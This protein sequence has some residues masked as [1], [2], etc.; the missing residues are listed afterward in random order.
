MTIT[1]N[2]YGATTEEWDAFVALSLQDVRPIVCDPSIPASPNS[3]I[4]D[5]AKIPSYVQHDGTYAGVFGWQRFQPTP[6]DVAK[7]K[8]HPAHGIGMVGRKYKA[9]DLDIDDPDL[10]MDVVDYIDAFVGAWLPVRVRKGAA[11]RLMIFT[12]AE[13][14]QDKTV[15]KVVINTDKDGKIELLGDRQQ[16]QVAGTHTKS[17]NRVEWENGLPTDAPAL[18]MDQVIE[19]IRGLT[20]TFGIGTSGVVAGNVVVAD[21]RSIDQL[22]DEDDELQKVLESEYY[23]ATLSDGKIAVAC[24]WHHLHESTGGEL[25]DDLTKTVYF[26][27]GLGGLEQSRFIC[28]HTSHGKKTIQHFLEKLDYVPQVFEVMNPDE[29][30]EDTERPVFNAPTKAAIPGTPANLVRAL[31]WSDGTGLEIATDELSHTM[32]IRDDSHSPWRLFKD[33][34]FMRVQLY[35]ASKFGFGSI[36]RDALRDAVRYVAENKSFDSAKDWLA[37]IEWDGVQRIDSLPLRVLGVAADQVAYTQ[38]VMRYLLTAAVARVLRPGTKADMIP[39][40]IGAQGTRKSTFVGQLVP[41]DRKSAWYVEVDLSARDDN[42]SRESR[43]KIIAELPELRGLATRDHESIKAWVTKTEDTWVPKYR[44]YAVTVARRYVMVG[45]GNRFDFLSDVTGN[46]RWLP[47]H[48]C[49]TRTHIDTDYMEKYIDQLWA[50]ARDLYERKGVMWREAETLARDEHVKYTRVDPYSA[51]VRR[52]LE[53]R[54]WIDG[55]TTDDV[56]TQAIRV[57]VRNLTGSHIYRVE[58]VLRLMDMEKDPITDQW[59]LTLA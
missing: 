28:Q 7:W 36:G 4:T 38:A 35:L 59:R 51:A 40:L 13:E 22:S 31:S 25:S 58:S 41:K 20:E 23:R 24:P 18:T 27:A 30:P 47:M 16:Y 49:V 37:G 44:E 57:E 19:L 33:T 55:F 54:G 9:L 12:L 48:V 1:A 43:G 11:R 53:A 56:V 5:P 34:D 46:R 45:T 3:S 32:M 6:A 8:N 2:T 14:D 42:T 50:E 15:Q 21:T 29:K 52:W 39:V 17:G 10:V 26:P